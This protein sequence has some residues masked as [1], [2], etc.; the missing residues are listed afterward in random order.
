MATVS[1]QKSIKIDVKE[2]ADISIEDKISR[3]KIGEYHS[4]AEI[5]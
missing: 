2:L 3:Q 1:V 4:L 5:H